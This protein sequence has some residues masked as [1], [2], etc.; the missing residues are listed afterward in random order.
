MALDWL[1]MQF[2]SHIAVPKCVIFGLI[3]VLFL[4]GRSAFATESHEDV[5]TPEQ[6]SWLVQHEPLRYVPHQF[7]PPL[8]F[9]T[10]PNTVGGLTPQLLGLVAQKLNARVEFVPHR[11]AAC[12]TIRLGKADMAGAVAQTQAGRKSSV[13]L[14]R[15]STLQRFLR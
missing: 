3:A 7:A 9:Q 2:G 4:D 12:E 1:S 10:G 14:S 11:Q 8:E 6:R 15:L 5:L 13:S